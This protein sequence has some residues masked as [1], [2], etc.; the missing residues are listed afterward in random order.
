MDNEDKEV[1][2]INKIIRNVLAALKI[3]YLIIL[4]PHHLIVILCTWMMGLASER[5]PKYL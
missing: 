3:P 1:N 4:V 2:M 5:S